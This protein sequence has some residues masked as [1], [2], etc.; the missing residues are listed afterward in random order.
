[1]TMI[2][3]TASKAA[4][5]AKADATTRA[6]PIRSARTPWDLANPFITGR[7]T[8]I[9]EGES[10][11]LQYLVT[12]EPVNT[13]EFGT[14]SGTGTGTSAGYGI[15]NLVNSTVIPPA[16]ITTY[17]VRDGEGNLIATYEEAAKNGREVLELLIESYQ[18]RN[19]PLPEPSL[20]YLEVA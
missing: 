1:M 17:Y 8:S 19:L 7:D 9:C 13:L 15:Y 6:K 2:D 11:D 20:A 4:T 14:G 10:I 18:E 16:G 5:A 3:P 12:G